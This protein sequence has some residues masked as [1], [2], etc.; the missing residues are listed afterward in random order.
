MSNVDCRPAEATT[1]R[2]HSSTNTADQLCCMQ[3]DVLHCTACS[4]ACKAQVAMNITL[5]RSN[6]SYKPLLHSAT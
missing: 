4:V 5:C 1:A 6:L 2:G 3:Q